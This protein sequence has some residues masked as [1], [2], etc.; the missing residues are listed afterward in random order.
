MLCL[1]P[2]FLFLCRIRAHK[3]EEK[4]PWQQS[5]Y[6]ASS[7]PTAVLVLLNLGL[8]FFFQMWAPTLCAKAAFLKSFSNIFFQVLTCS[9]T[10]DVLSQ[11]LSVNTAAV[12]VSMHFCD[13][14]SASSFLDLDL[15]WKLVTAL[16]K[17]VTAAFSL[18]YWARMAGWTNQPGLYLW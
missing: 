1:T 14:L 6:C 13:Y 18:V 11:V 17:C 8:F 7:P 15:C 5:R 2:P 9:I 10:W 16:A 3:C 4:Q 12:W